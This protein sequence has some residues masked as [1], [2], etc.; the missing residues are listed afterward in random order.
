MSTKDGKVIRN[1]TERLQQGS[2]LRVHRRRPAASA[3]TRCRGCRGRRAATASPTSPA[4]RST[5]RS[6]S[7]T[8]SRRKI[9]QAHRAEDGRHAGIARHQPRRHATSRSRR[10]SGAIGDIFIVDIETGEIKNLTNDA[11]RRLRA[12]LL[13]RRQVDRLPRARQRQRQAVPA[14]PRDR[15]EDAAHVRHAR[16]RRRA[17]HRRRTR[18]CSRRPRSIRTSRSTRRWRATATSTTSGRS[19]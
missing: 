14:R 17:V 12:D 10:C 4:P 5:R 1:L 19:T 2:R 18:S 15:Q 6:S 11:V 8:S 9:E 3:T 16:R 13:A 7:R